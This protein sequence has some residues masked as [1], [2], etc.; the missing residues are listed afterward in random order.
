MRLIKLFVVFLLALGSTC[1][2]ARAESYEEYVKTLGGGN[3][4]SALSAQW[5]EVSKTDKYTSYIDETSIAKK[6]NGLVL[7]TSGAKYFEPEKDVI[8]ESVLHQMY[9]EIS[10]NVREFRFSN[11][12]MPS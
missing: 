8:N 3:H 10:R 6:E 7:Y 9:C 1:N 12:P 2:E 4:T 5:V 11:T